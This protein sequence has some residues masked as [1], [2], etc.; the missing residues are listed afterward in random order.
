MLSDYRRVIYAA[1]ITERTTVPMNEMR[2]RVLHRGCA[3]IRVTLEARSAHNSSW[4]RCRR[5]RL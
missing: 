5:T 4:L 2:I 3:A 1:G